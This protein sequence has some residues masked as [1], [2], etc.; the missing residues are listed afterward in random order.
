MNNVLNSKHYAYRTQSN[1]I[2][3]LVKF[4]SP[5]KPAIFVSVT[6]VITA[7]KAAVLPKVKRHK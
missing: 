5:S 7:N 3:K 2:I 1:I 4:Q 6:T